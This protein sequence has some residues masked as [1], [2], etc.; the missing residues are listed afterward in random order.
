MELLPKLR[1]KDGRGGRMIWYWCKYCSLWFRA[2]T[3]TVVRCPK[4]GA[5]IT[6]FTY[7]P[8]GRMDEDEDEVED[9]E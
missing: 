3:T 6:E 9:A 7:I 4:C 1:S 5:D 8:N 2:S